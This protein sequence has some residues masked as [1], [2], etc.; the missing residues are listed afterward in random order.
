MRKPR[1]KSKKTVKNADGTIVELDG[2]KLQC[3][4]VY[5]TLNVTQE[6]LAEFFRVSR[7]T[8]QA[9]LKEAKCLL[10][11]NQI[12]EMAQK[13]FQ[14]MVPDALNV[15]SRALTLGKIL[16][17]S[18]SLGAARDVVKNN[19][20][21]TDKPDAPPAVNVQIIIQERQEKQRL[22]LAAFGYELPSE[23]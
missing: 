23:N 11:E 14:G 3:L 22:G 2:R 12:L 19:S 8:I 4:F 5:H 15:Y 10:D 1:G 9:W 20:I 13:R 21:L 18:T 7:N 17:D 6:Q 16:P